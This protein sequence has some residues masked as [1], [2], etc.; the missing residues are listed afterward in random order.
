MIFTLLVAALTLAVVK[1]LLAKLATPIPVMVSAAAVV[2]LTKLLLIFK[3]KIP[4]YSHQTIYINKLY[5]Y[6][7]KSILHAKYYKKVT[8]II[9]VRKKA[10]SQI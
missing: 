4:P 9:P 8:E 10:L 1:L 5:F 6:I 7:T 3:I 2:N